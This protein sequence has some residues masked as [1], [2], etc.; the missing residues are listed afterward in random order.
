MNPKKRKTTNDDSLSSIQVPKYNYAPLDINEG[1][2]TKHG[3]QEQAQNST[4]AAAAVVP[5]DQYSDSSEIEIS[6]PSPANATNYSIEDS[7]FTDET[8]MAGSHAHGMIIDSC[9]EHAILLNQDNTLFL[10][11]NTQPLNSACSPPNQLIQIQP[12][13][14]ITTTPETPNTDPN[15]NANT[16]QVIHSTASS[17]SLDRVPSTLSRLDDDRT[18]FLHYVDIKTI[19][20]SLK[21][22]ISA[23]GERVPCLSIETSLQHQ[24]N[25]N[26]RIVVQGD[27]LKS[28]MNLT[29]KEWTA[30][31][32][33]LT[34]VGIFWFGSNDAEPLTGSL[35]HRAMHYLFKATSKI[36]NVHIA[37]GDSDLETA[38]VIYKPNVSTDNITS[39]ISPFVLA[40][41]KAKAQ[42]LNN[43]KQQ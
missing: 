24:C 13:Q 42:E 29:D 16:N 8:I 12:S 37:Y 31:K 18:E 22:V 20:S 40:A 28:I 36:S 2:N 34:T 32:A 14:S 7:L 43:N 39:C 4:T 30:V 23:M 25:G 33:I 38:R 6:Q 35:L 21:T 10:E 11:I 26:N 3:H 5:H 17:V 27:A 1:K 41:M 9:A 15:E 19:K